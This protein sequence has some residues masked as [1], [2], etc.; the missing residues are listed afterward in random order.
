MIY[1]VALVLVVLCVLVIL[2]APEID[3]PD[4]TGLRADHGAH[5]VISNIDFVVTL[6]VLVVMAAFTFREREAIST[7]FDDPSHSSL[8]TFLL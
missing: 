8:C 1:R 5:F 2:I 3:L 6:F 4:S 7:R